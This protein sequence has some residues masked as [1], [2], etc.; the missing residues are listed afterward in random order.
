MT[1]NI[2]CLYSTDTRFETVKATSHY[3]GSYFPTYCAGFFVGQCTVLCHECHDPETDSTD[4]PIMHADESDYPGFWCHD[5][6]RTLDTHIVAY[7]SGPGSE[8]YQE[9]ANE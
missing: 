8:V 1:S 4:S 7:E 9:Y 3:D 2:V 5:C 6:Q